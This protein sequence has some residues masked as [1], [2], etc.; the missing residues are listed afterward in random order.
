MEKRFWRK[1]FGDLDEKFIWQGKERHG[2]QIGQPKRKQKSETDV[3]EELL[4][5]IEVGYKL[6]AAANCE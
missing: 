1:F 6:I 5:K 4:H 2:R 3:S